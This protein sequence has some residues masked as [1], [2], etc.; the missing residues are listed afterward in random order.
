VIEEYL[1]LVQFGMVCIEPTADSSLGSKKR[2]RI[3]CCPWDACA[4]RAMI[5]KEHGQLSSLEVGESIH[6]MFY[7]SMSSHGALLLQTSKKLCMRELHLR[8]ESMVGNYV[9]Q[10]YYRSW[11]SSM[12]CKCSG[13][14]EF[15][16][17]R[18]QE[19]G[20]KFTEIGVCVKAQK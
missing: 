5:K 12:G 15:P 14:E 8:K 11:D 1:G 7:Y 10:S 16:W 4:H 6:V 2:T 18:G 3:R 19:R 17:T 13:W 20:G 9:K